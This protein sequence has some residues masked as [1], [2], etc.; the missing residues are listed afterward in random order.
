MLAPGFNPKDTAETYV[1]KIMTNRKRIEQT[2]A[3]YEQEQKEKLDSSRKEAEE[4]KSVDS[5]K[6]I[7]TLEGDKNG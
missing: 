5:D 4:T 2:I 6:D 1:R 7:K 3:R